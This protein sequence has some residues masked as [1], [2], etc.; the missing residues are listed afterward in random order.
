MM[1]D[2]SHVQRN[3]NNQNDFKYYVR[4]KERHLAKGIEI[5]EFCKEV[6]FLS[7]DNADGKSSET[8]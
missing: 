5:K 1:E 8:F 4:Q 6:T 2:D 7:A 3:L